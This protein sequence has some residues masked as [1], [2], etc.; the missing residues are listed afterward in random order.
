[1]T[2][3]FIREELLIQKPWIGTVDKERNE[4]KVRRTRTGIF[5][6]GISSLEVIGRSTEYESRKGI[7]IEIKPV[8]YVALGSVWVTIFL[9]IFIINYFND[10]AGWG[11]L[12]GFLLIQ[13]LALILDLNKTED[14]IRNYINHVRSNALQ[15]NVSSPYNW[16]I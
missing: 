8:W 4:F 5:K 15:Q 16:A 12:F 10:I 2:R 3:I 13:V 11:I 9:S 14:K 6:T 7:E 1:L